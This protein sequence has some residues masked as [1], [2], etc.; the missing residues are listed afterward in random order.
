MAKTPV[1]FAKSSVAVGATTVAKITKIQRNL[2]I[3]E[4]DVTGSEDYEAGSLLTNEQRITIS[5]DE[6]LDIEGVTLYDDATATERLEAGQKAFVEAAENGTEVVLKVLD[7]N[8][9]GY[10]YT[11]FITNLQ[12]S[13]SVGDVWKF[14]GNFRVNSRSAVTPP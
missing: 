6:T 8:G 7:A 10:D 9:F 11:G 14:T 3:N 13:A 12:E 1:R 2:S 5:R 4:A